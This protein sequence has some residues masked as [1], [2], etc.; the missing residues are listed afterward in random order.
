MTPEE[1]Q[2]RFIPHS[3]VPGV[4]DPTRCALCGY[5]AGEKPWR[6]LRMEGRLDG[7]S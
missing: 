7:R 1:A 2:F 6:L 4:P 3:F 5:R